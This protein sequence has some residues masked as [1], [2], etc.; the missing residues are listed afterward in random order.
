MNQF[1]FQDRVSLSRSSEELT[2]IVDELSSNYEKR[3]N[4]VSKIPHMKNR[5]SEIC[6]PLFC[7]MPLIVAV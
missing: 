1:S 6:V 7:Y 5:T 2:K 4:F 3:E